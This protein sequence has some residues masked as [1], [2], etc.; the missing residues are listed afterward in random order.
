MAV[1]YGLLV[2]QNLTN[3]ANPNP[4]IEKF[5]RAD[6]TPSDDPWTPSDD[7]ESPYVIG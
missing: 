1:V 3:M 6:D 7:P 4:S 5:D 2:D